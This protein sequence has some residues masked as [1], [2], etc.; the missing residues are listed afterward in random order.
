MGVAVLQ[1]RAAKV[2]Q[3]GIAVGGT[4]WQRGGTWCSC[5]TWVGAGEEDHN[6]DTDSG[7]LRW[8]AVAAG[9]D[10]IDEAVRGAEP[11]VA[12]SGLYKTQHSN[13]AQHTCTEEGRPTARRSCQRMS[14]KQQQGPRAAVR[15]LAGAHMDH[16]CPLR[17]LARRQRP[18]PAAATVP[19]RLAGKFSRSP[20]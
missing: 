6:Q 15:V 3:R 9:G 8:S 19:L 20:P 14:S 13:A 18:L 11:P 7:V 16:P 10:E 5:S 2:P 1:I 12:A 4:C 17:P